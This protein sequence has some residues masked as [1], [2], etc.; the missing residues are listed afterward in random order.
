MAYFKKTI[1]GSALF[2]AGLGLGFMT[3]AVIFVNDHPS[4]I[5]KEQWKT[6]TPT[7]ST[8]PDFSHTS[9]NPD[10]IA[11]ILKLEKEGDSVVAGV[12]TTTT[13]TLIAPVAPTPTTVVTTMPLPPSTSPPSSTTSTSETTTSTIEVKSEE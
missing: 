2:G 3:T 4:I 6:F 1:F 9:L 5:I 13:T 8:C 10:E 11:N 12:T 7:Q